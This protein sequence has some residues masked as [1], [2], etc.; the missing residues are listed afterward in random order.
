[1]DHTGEEKAKKR[2]ENSMCQEVPEE[3]SGRRP[4]P[5][6]SAEMAHFQIS[7][8][9]NAGNGEWGTGKG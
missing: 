3:D 4:W 9:R 1:M 5:S 2:E 6:P 8:G 7:I